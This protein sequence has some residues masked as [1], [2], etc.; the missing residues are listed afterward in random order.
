MIDSLKLSLNLAFTNARGWKTDQKIVVIESDDWGSIRMPS[1]ET[2]NKLLKKGIRVDKSLY[3]TIDALENRDDLNCL[4]DLLLNNATAN[5]H[6]IFTFNTVM[7]NPDF[8]KINTDKFEKFYG[9]NLFESYKNYYGE[10]LEPMWRT[11]I[12]EE[13]M[14]PQYHAREHLNAYLWLYDLRLGIKDTKNAFD[15]NFF[16][17]KTKTSSKLRNH[18][19]ATYFSETNEEFNSVTIAL[20]DG[21]KQFNDIFGFNSKTFI[22]SNYIWPK[23]LEAELLK[24]NI[25]TIQGQIKQTSTIFSKD[26]ISY[27]RHYTG[28][29]NEINQ[30]YSVRN[31]IFEPYLDQTLNWAELALKQIDN[32][33]F[34]KTPA[35][36]TSHRINYASHISVKNRD[37][38]LRYLNALL[39]KINT[40]YPDVIFLS[41]NQLSEL[42]RLTN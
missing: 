7:Q 36:I 23:Q 40:K 41:S 18:Y 29:K 1:K 11:A 31:V 24:L 37:S 14:I 34:W 30:T 39:K 12:K 3:D 13:I 17:L 15:L 38:S 27:L 42:M 10:D 25:D 26:K 19:L 22:A 16:G 21:V 35:I 5:T 20:K 2:Y 8:E 28:E 4:F 6:P 9:I 33:F 32:A